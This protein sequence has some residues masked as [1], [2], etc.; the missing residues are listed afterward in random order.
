MQAEVIVREMEI[1]YP[2]LRY[3]RLYAVPI[4]ETVMNKSQ[5]MK[6][7]LAIIITD[8]TQDK[9]SLDQR[10]ES[11]KVSSIMD[12]AAGV[13]HELGNPLNSINIHLQVLKR[14]FT[15]EKNNPEKT[16]KSLTT[17]INEV[18]RLDG[19]I[20]HFL[21]AIRPQT[22]DFKKINLLKIIEETVHLKKDEL[23]AKEI[24]IS[25]EAGV[26]EPIINGDFEQLKQVFFNVIG[27]A[28]DAISCNSEIRILTGREDRFV[29]V[30]IIDHGSGINK[31]DLS[32]VFEPYYT[33]KKSGHGIGMMIV[34]RIMRDHGGDI[35]IDSKPDAGTIVTLRFPRSSSRGRLLESSNTV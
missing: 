9:V 2:E 11:E 27:N 35:G 10:I 19:I 22:P 31:E 25:M 5:N 17:C 28:I 13:A 29:F 34:H 12:L 32:K 8:I 16:K 14:N 4:E 24:N 23:S 15:S 20:A 1:S 18:E 6:I 7:G 33:T 30:K 26:R 21:K 3:I